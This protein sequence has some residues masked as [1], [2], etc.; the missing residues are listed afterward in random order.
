MYIYCFFF[1]FWAPTGGDSVCMSVC[2]V[3]RQCCIHIVVHFVDLYSILAGDGGRSMSMSCTMSPMATCLLV[4][5]II[6]MSDFQEDGSPVESLS[7]LWCHGSLEL[8]RTPWLTFRRLTIWQSRDRVPGSITKKVTGYWLCGYKK[9]YSKPKLDYCCWPS[10]K[11]YFIQG[12][13]KG[14]S[15]GTFLRYFWYSG[16][17]PHLS[18]P[19]FSNKGTPKINKRVI[20]WRKY[21]YTFMNIRNTEIA[22]QIVLFNKKHFEAEAAYAKCL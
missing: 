1:V 19:D 11:E 6:I 21:H 17:L 3:S 15:S 16:S 18:I 10:V 9:N 22:N 14:I 20:S 2:P 13:V 4:S 7:I 8:C 5:S 12:L